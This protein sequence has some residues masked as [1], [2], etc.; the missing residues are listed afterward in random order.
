MALNDRPLCRH[1]RLMNRERT[2][3][4]ALGAGTAIAAG[5]LARRGAASAWRYTLAE[6]PP[7]NIEDQDPGWPRILAWAAVSGFCVAF[8]RVAGRGVASRV[9]QR[10][11]GQRPPGY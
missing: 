1:R 11:L 10:S 9:W 6:E 2:L 7:V 5:I 3:W 8:A 4:L